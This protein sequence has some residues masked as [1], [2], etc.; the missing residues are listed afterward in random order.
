[1]GLTTTAVG[2]WPVGMLLAGWIAD[3]A[4]ALGAMA[5]LGVAGLL[6]L[7]AIAA[8]PARRAR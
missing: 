4:G 7:A 6:G 5:V 1:M 8:G 3:H 2:M